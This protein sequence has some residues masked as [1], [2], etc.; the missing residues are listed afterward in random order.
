MS[1][2]GI[3]RR[4]ALTAAIGVTAAASLASTGLLAAPAVAAPQFLRN[5][6]LKEA[7]RRVEARRRH[8]LTNRPSANQWEMEKAAD[9]G[10][11]I[12]S[13][14][15]PGTG[16][17]VSVRKGDIAT[18]LV[19]VIRRFHYE[20]DT[21]GLHG[22]PN[23]IE[24]WMAPSAVRDSRLP[25]ANQASGTAVVIRPGSYPPGVRGSFT[26]G[27]QLII[28]DIIADTEGVVRWG[29]EDRRAYEGLF[30]LTVPPGDARLERVAAKVGT[31]GAIPGAGAGTVP[32]VTDP[33]RLR[34][35]ARYR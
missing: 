2:T 1:P 33:S 13:R 21:L 34:R 28:R 5:D 20:V 15:V 25:E 30:Y 11:D 9:A 32:D 27:Q 22:E 16:L 8:L 35:A 14:P 18:V 7:L 17:N 31:W 3:T 10:G 4:Y 24:G 19:H 12:A 6:E 29:G 23:P 26:T